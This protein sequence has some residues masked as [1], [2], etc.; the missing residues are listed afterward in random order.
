MLGGREQA[1]LLMELS[2]LN[3][4]ECQANWN[5]PKFN[6]IIRL[7]PFFNVGIFFPP[8]QDTKQRKIIFFS[9]AASLRRLKSWTALFTTFRNFISPIYF[10]GFEFFSV[11][12]GLVLWK[13]L[14]NE[15]I[16]N[17]HSFYIYSTA[18]RLTSA[19]VYR[20]NSF[21]PLWMTSEMCF[22]LTLF[23]TTFRILRAKF[24]YSAIYA[25]AEVITL[26]RY[27]ALAVAWE[28]PA[29]M[30]L[31]IQWLDVSWGN[32]RRAYD[33]RVWKSYWTLW[34]SFANWKDR[35]ENVFH[36]TTWRCPLS[37]VCRGRSPALSQD[38][39]REKRFSYIVRGKIPKRGL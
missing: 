16:F 36:L 8:Q 35:C 5:K 25:I 28:S 21:A 18:L 22:A 14:E 34:R 39:C 11:E 19:R 27:S 23:N 31:Y 30:M 17:F 2:T 29:L 7:M 38:D 9:C 6:T 20:H 12:K 15:G 3:P 4:S 37:S 24:N 32:T 13:M 33:W 1:L 26:Q 10:S